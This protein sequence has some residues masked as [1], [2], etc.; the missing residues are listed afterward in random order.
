MNR[1]PLAWLVYQ[2]IKQ[3]INKK[4]IILNLI[5]NVPFKEISQ[6]I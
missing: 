3:K 1:R 4:F 2:K 6:N 5:F